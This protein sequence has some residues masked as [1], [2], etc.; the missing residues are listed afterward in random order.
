MRDPSSRSI[1]DDSGC[2]NDLPDRVPAYEYGGG[3]QLAK[4]FPS[5]SVS[6][7]IS[8]KEVAKHNSRESCWIIVHG[9]ESLSVF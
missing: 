3:P 4:P 6:M 5:S 7:S 1:E 9:M 8:T 2:E